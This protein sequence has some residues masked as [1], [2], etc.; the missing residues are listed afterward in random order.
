MNTQLYNQLIQAKNFLITVEKNESD[1]VYR[2]EEIKIA[3]ANHHVLT[4]KEMPKKFSW[5][6]FLLLL[7]CCGA[8]IIYALYIFFHN[9]KAKKKQKQLDELYNSPKEVQKRKDNE[10]YAEF[11]KK[12]YE[13]KRIEYG[14]YFSENYPKYSYIFPYEIKTVEHVK[15]HIKYVD[16]LIEHVK[17]GASTL[18]EAQQRH[19]ADLRFIANLEEKREQREIEERRYKEELNALNTIARNQEKTVDELER[20]YNDTFKRR[21]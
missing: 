6:I 3:N 1:L 18:S 9:Q 8:G 4:P 7:E 15:S 17:N 12:E 10:M 20:L 11:R 5:I 19:G 14:R 21:F 13:A 16:G 2:K